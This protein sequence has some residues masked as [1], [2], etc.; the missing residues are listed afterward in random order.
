MALAAALRSIGEL[1]RC[2]EVLL[3]TIALV[4][5]DDEPRRLELTAW[6]AAVEHGLG[7]HEE[8]HQRLLRAWE[9]AR[10]PRDAPRRAA[11]QVELAVDG[12]YTLDFEQT[13]TMGGGALE[14]ARAARATRR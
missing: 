6:C 8:A 14:S 3:E 7:R 2:R 10:R 4:G 13:L 11:L 9:R 5:E 1:E 12:L